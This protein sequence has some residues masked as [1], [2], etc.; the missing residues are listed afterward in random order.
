MW[1]RFLWAPRRNTCCGRYPRPAYGGTP[2]YTYT[3]TERCTLSR[4]TPSTCPYHSR[5][6][7]PLVWIGSPYR[8]LWPLQTKWTRMPQRRCGLRTRMTLSTS[9]VSLHSATTRAALITS[10]WQRFLWAPRRNT[11][12]GRY[13]RPAYGGTP[14]YTYTPTERC[15]LSRHTPSTCP[16]HS[17]PRELLVWIGSPY[18]VLWPLQTKWT[19]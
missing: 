7:E 4:H 8:V 6:R 2:G 18:R 16:Y 10:M 1:Q 9:K 12:C 11:C 15:T 17:R 5:P 14:G 19:R 13:P 3:P